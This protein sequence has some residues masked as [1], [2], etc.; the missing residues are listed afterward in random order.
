MVGKPRNVLKKVPAHSWEPA[1]IATKTDIKKKSAFVTTSFILFILL[2]MVVMYADD[3]VGQAVSSGN[4][5]ENCYGVSLVGDIDVGKSFDVPIKVNLKN[6]S[7][8]KVDFLL[9]YDK[10]S[11]DIEC[12]DISDPLDNLFNVTNPEIVVDKLIICGNG[13]VSF[14]YDVT[15]FTDNLING[16][17]EIARFKLIA[18]ESDF[19][20][21]P[22]KTLPI[23]FNKFEIKE[24]I[25]DDKIT[26]SPYVEFNI[27][28]NDPEGRVVSTETEDGPDTTTD[29]INE[30]TKTSSGGGSRR[31]PLWSC[32]V[33][34]YCNSTLE[35]YRLCY[36][37][38]R[39]YQ[40][41]V[42]VRSCEKCEES[43]I[44]REWNECDSGLQERDCLDQHFCGTTFLKPL[45]RKACAV[46]EETLADYVAPEE[47]VPIDYNFDDYVM[48]EIQQPTQLS[49][50]DKNFNLLLSLM[51]FLLVGYV[52]SMVWVIYESKMQYNVDY[53][54]LKNWIN[55]EMQMGVSKTKVRK[56]LQENN[57][58]NEKEIEKA[59]KEL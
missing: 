35:Q 11:F 34:S 8:A 52:V 59:F 53:S 33:W 43:W 16:S 48:P 30:T 6:K 47:I 12:S 29:S 10:S 40:N 28:I 20:I 9:Y 57:A 24:Y 25:T 45:E 39:Y 58:W 38:N 51:I 1:P 21:Y 7:S 44:C 2:I 14:Y 17:V 54:K 27:A 26:L 15:S 46:A 55:Q 32:D 18:K 31:R 56:I 22:Y 49:F 36:D 3:F 4:I 50:V 19:D 13:K 37:Q 41:T 5:C 23:L 42:D